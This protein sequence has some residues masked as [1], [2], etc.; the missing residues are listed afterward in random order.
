MPPKAKS[1]VEHV[2]GIHCILNISSRIV[3]VGTGLVANP[4]RDTFKLKANGG[5][6]AAQVRA[7]P[8]FALLAAAAADSSSSHKATA[9]AQPSSSAEDSELEP[10]RR[11]L[12]DRAEL[13]A[14]SYSEQV[15]LSTCSACA[16]E[17][18][19]GV[20]L[21][22]C[23]GC[24]CF[25]CDVQCDRHGSCPHDSCVG[26]EDADDEAAAGLGCQCAC[27]QNRLPPP[28]FDCN[29]SPCYCPSMVGPG[30]RWINPSYSKPGRRRPLYLNSC[31]ELVECPAPTLH[32]EAWHVRYAPWVSRHPDHSY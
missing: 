26:D 31:G 7:R 4:E 2:D 17:P 20:T 19:S 28:C 11:R 8:R 30:E 10:Q 12:L 21:V 29:S 24:G 23:A 13:Q 9:A 27:C 16:A 22:Q 5:S 6:L 32:G 25:F 18:A 1:Q 3:V 14:L 15:R